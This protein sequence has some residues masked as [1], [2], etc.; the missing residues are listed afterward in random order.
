MRID[1]LEKIARA[2]GF[3]GACDE[4]LQA[5]T[6]AQSSP[7]IPAPRSTA[8]Q[9]TALVIVDARPA[10]PSLQSTATWLATAPVNAARSLS[11]LLGR[12][13]PA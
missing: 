3:A 6:L 12:G 5:D 9:S 4:D 8:V 1:V 10:G 11:T 13:A 7:D 2:A